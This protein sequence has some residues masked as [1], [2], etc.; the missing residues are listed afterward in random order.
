MSQDIP[1]ALSFDDVL[2][3]PQ[4]SEIESR[5]EVNLTTKISPNLS[6]KIPIISTKMDTVT[7]IEMAIALGKM[8]GLG[9][10]PRFDTVESQADKVAKVK[11]ANVQVAAAVGVKEGFIERAQALVNAGVDVLDVDVAHGHM[12]KTIEA[13]KLLKNKYG[14]KITLFSE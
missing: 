13:T 12:K 9:I 2:L 3:V 11:K 5:S 8:G 14:K 1:L 6:L 4:Y 10:L 7:G